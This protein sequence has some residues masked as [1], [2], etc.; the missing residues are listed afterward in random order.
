[1]NCFIKEATLDDIDFLLKVENECFPDPWNFD[2]L[3]SEVLAPHATYSI[4]YVDQ[5]AVGYYSF[6]HIF[7]EA[8]IM[9]VAILP[10]YQGKGYG[11]KMMDL[12]LNQTLE[13]SLPHITLEVRRGNDKAISLYKKFGFKLA[14]VRPRYYMDGEDALIFWLYR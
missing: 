2:M 11:N 4:F 13:L 7:D 10:D 6:L 12:L 5:T 3:E 8:H 14:G 9:N 1:M